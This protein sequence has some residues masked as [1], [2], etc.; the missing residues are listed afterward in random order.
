MIHGAIFDLDGT[1]LDSMQFWSE[2]GDLFVLSQGK[3]P[4]PGLCVALAPL[5]TLESAQYLRSEYGIEG[6]DQ[7]LM[8]TINGLIFA[9]YR[10]VIPFKPGAEKFLQSLRDQGVKLCVATAT[11]KH[12]V[13]EA[14][15]RLDG[16]QY[17][18]AI[19]TCGEV[20]CGKDQPVVYDRALEALGTDK[21]ETV[22]FED[23]VH[24]IRTAKAAGY[25]VAAVQDQ[26]AECDEAEIRRLADWYLEAY[27]DWAGL[28]IQRKEEAL[29]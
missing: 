27:E 19:L 7:E 1:L 25:Q 17:F 15:R 14:L 3:T 11:D 10:D 6:T 24:A 20:G 4:R 22:I 23:A 8:D 28:D 13:L 2:L 16:E 9:K 5:S 29:A 12:L 21:K 18:D 26:A